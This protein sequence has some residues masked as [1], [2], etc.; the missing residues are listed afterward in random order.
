MG[1]AVHAVVVYCPV[2]SQCEDNDP[3]G[4]H[5]LHFFAYDIRI[6]LA[7]DRFAFDLIEDEIGDV[8]QRRG[9]GKL[10]RHGRGVDGYFHSLFRRL[11]NGVIPAGR[12]VLKKHQIARFEM[13]EHLVHKGF[14]DAS[15]GPCENDDGVLSAR[16]DLNDRVACGN[17]GIRLQER[18]VH[19]FHRQPVFQ[20]GSVCSD[21]PRMIGLR[22][23]LRQGY[24]LVQ[25]F[26]A[27]VNAPPR[28][29]CRFTG[30]HKMVHGINIIQ[31]Q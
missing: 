16:Y 18:D 8:L 5:F 12:L 14:G 31:I 19:A 3:V 2:S 13:G 1:V 28:S 29:G 9:G 10:I 30:F 27:P 22:S 6:G 25:T 17:A 24:R 21:S 7:C 23:C 20:H 15:V 11:F 26:A 4:E